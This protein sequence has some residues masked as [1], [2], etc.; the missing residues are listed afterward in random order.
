MKQ[1]DLV[2]KSYLFGFVV[3]VLRENFEKII[4]VPQW[5]HYVTWVMQLKVINV[6]DEVVLKVN[7]QACQEIK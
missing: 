7:R 4:L 3:I 6:V 2:D 5:P 1:Y